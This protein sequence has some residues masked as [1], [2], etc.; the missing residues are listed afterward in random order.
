MFLDWMSFTWKRNGTRGGHRSFLVLGGW[1][2]DGNLYS[3]G[4]LCVLPG[5]VPE[6]RKDSETG[7][8]GKLNYGAL[9]QR[10]QLNLKKLWIWG[11]PSDL[12]RIGKREPG[13]HSHSPSLNSHCLQAIFGR[14]VTLSQVV[15]FS[16]GQEPRW[17]TQLRAVSSQHPQ[18]L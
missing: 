18:Q 13:L 3:W 2:W 8:R 17:G 12:T 14:A 15:L 10:F 16:R 4:L 5:W 1:L 6:G 7:Q 9:K 11:G